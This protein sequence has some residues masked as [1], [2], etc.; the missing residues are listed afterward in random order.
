MRNETSF[1]EPGAASRMLG[2]AIRATSAEVRHNTIQASFDAADGSVAKYAASARQSPVRSVLDLVDA[3]CVSPKDP[4]AVAIAENGPRL[5]N[6]PPAQI[7]E[8][9][10]KA[11]R[12]VAASDAPRE[13]R[14]QA[15]ALSKAVGGPGVE[16]GLE[17]L[18]LGLDGHDRA[19]AA[20]LKGFAAAT[21]QAC[22]TRPE[23]TRSRDDER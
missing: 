12:D 5:S 21:M 16:A 19:Q 4:R 3:G 6:M 13:A 15:A 14:V 2:S 11:L 17:K 1:D 7:Q 8:W 23:K 9:T 18:V 22:S 10:S 20:A